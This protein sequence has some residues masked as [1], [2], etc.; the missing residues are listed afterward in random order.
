M[1]EK[2]ALHFFIIFSACNT[3]FSE[4]SPVTLFSFAFFQFFICYVTLTLSKAVKVSIGC[5]VF[6]PRNC[7]C[8][9][10]Y[11]LLFQFLIIKE[12]GFVRSIDIV[13][14]NHAN[15]IIEKLLYYFNYVILI[16]AASLVITKRIIDQ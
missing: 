12:C 10:R 4:K 5:F 1:S 8:M 11:S 9:C 15:H 7:S 14:F 16:E 13:F 6:F 3:I 2:K